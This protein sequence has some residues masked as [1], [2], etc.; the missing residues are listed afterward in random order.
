M[1]IITVINPITQEQ[2]VFEL[3][4]EDFIST[5][6][7]EAGECNLSFE[8]TLKLAKERSE[9]EAQNLKASVQMASS[10]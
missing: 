8:E 4:D 5:Y 10:S 6:V 2:L 9:H 3:T 1:D 7:P